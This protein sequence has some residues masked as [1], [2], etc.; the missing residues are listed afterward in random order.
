MNENQR[1]RYEL[2]HKV[3]CD[4][5]KAKACYD[6]VMAPR[7]DEKKE[8]L[9]D[10]IYLCYEDGFRTLY[11]VHDVHLNHGAI[12]HVGIKLGRMKIGVKL[13]DACCDSMPENDTEDYFYEEIDDAFDTFNLGKECSDFMLGQGD[14]LP[15]DVE[16]GEWIPSLGEMV[17]IS[18]HRKWLNA[19][20]RY[21]QGDE[22]KESYWTSTRMNN[23]NLWT[24]DFYDCRVAASL[25]KHN[26]KKV[27]MVCKF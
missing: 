13:F 24:I 19:A 1:M 14:I 16:D 5:E 17:F 4:V 23:A 7:E 15:C 22:L 12:D 3:G 27:R 20:I 8:E 25:C 6:F 18:M 11:P 10:G 26:T 2:L 21:A 9:L